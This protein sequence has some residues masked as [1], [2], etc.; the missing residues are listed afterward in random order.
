MDLGYS[1]VAAYA[2]LISAFLGFL[3][4]Q[5]V[6]LNRVFGWDAAAVFAFSTCAVAAVAVLALAAYLWHEAW[7]VPRRHDSHGF[8]T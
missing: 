1:L 5:I 3:G 7:N 8:K 4:Y 2:T 6:K